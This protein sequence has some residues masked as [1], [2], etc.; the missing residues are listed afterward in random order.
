M[1][2]GPLWDALATD[3][4]CP[5][6]WLQRRVPGRL[7]WSTYAARRFP[8]QRPGL[9]FEVNQTDIPRGT[10]FPNSLGFRM[11]SE[12]AI[13]GRR[14]VITVALSSSSAQHDDLFRLLAEDVIDALERCT[15]RESMD[16][17]LS[18]LRLWQE[19]A[20]KHSDGLSRELQEGLYAELQCLQALLDELTAERAVAGWLGPQRAVHDFSFAGVELEVKASFDGTSFTVTSLDQLAFSPNQPLF[21]A[22]F[23][24]RDD[25]SGKTLVDQVN[26]VRA[27]LSGEP[28]EVRRQFEDK[29]LQYGFLDHHAARYTDTCWG[30]ASERYFRV[31][32]GF[33]RLNRDTV[34]SGIREASYRVD[35]TAC[36]PYQVTWQETATLI[37]PDHG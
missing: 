17:L 26:L 33:P 8:D 27:R 29:L 30:I 24:L 36:L 34:P 4:P 21:L 16:T 2:L 13:S 12:G 5:N 7:P 28:D 23:A 11:A 35:L 37:R 32:G 6:G 31:T 3:A 1:R 18:R 20:R 14:G 22:H 15:P 9:L 25:A 10:V 19:F